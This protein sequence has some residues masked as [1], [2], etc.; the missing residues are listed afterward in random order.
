[1]PTIENC[2]TL[3][4]ALPTFVKGVPFFGGSFAF[5]DAE[6][7]VA[8]GHLSAIDLD[9]GA[10]V[11]RHRENIMMWAGALSTEG[12]V[13]FTGNSEGHALALDAKTG[14]VLWR[15]P[16]SSVIRSQPV[17]YQVGGRTFVA[18]GSGGGLIVALVGAQSPLPQG[19]ALF[20]FEL[21]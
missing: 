9:T 11:W 10:V 18:I 19:S 7:G 1:M 13:V 5:P 3:E 4:K 12:G 16:T 6:Q 2:S 8:Y 21:E 15:F 17:A 14:K 20:V